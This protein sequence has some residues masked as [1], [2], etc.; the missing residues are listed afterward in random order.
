MRLHL[1]VLAGGVGLLALAAAAGS[2]TR[3]ED[4]WTGTVRVVENFSFTFTQATPSGGVITEVRTGSDDALYTLTGETTADGFHVASMT[5]SGSFR[6]VGSS[7]DPNVCVESY[8]P[9]G[10]WSYTGPARVRISYADGRFL[11]EP[12]LVDVT[13]RSVATKCSPGKTQTNTIQAPFGLGQ[14]TPPGIASP[15]GATVLQRVV[16]FT[17]AVAGSTANTSSATLT[18]DLRRADTSITPI[19]TASGTVLV[20]GKRYTSGQPIPYGSKV[21]VTNGRLTLRTDVG[22]LAVYGGGVSAVFK[23]LRLSEQGKPIVELRL[24]G[25]NF[26]VCKPA[27]RTLTVPAKKR[28]PGKTVRRLWGKG[29]GQYR[30]RGRYSS[31]AIRGTFWLTSDRCDG[32]LTSVKQGKVEV[33]D[34][35]KKV[36]VTVAAGKSYLARPRR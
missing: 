14:N 10:E 18:V 7:T 29:S 24:V 27:A 34:F 1:I 16:P 20:N 2:Q 32:T 17:L 3:A 35:V 33:F 22:T 4:T 9:L 23:L 25:G 12:Q 36:R 13:A 6:S 8:D 28:P 31:A 5:G 30:T 19:G 11:V 15:E 21:D 26:S